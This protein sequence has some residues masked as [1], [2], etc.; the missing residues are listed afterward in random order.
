MPRKYPV[1]IEVTY[2]PLAGGA[3]TV[4]TE[5]AGRPL[6]R[7]RR[8][9][10]FQTQSIGDQGALLELHNVGWPY[11]SWESGGIIRIRA[12]PL[13]RADW[14]LAT[15]GY[16][17][18][19]KQP[20]GHRPVLQVPVLGP[21]AV[22]DSIV[23]T[24]D[25]T[26]TDAAWTTMYD[27]L[28]TTYLTGYTRTITADAAT[29]TA[30]FLAG[31]RLREALDRIRRSLIAATG[32][33]WEHLASKNGATREIRLFKRATTVQA[34]IR[35]AD[36][37][38]GTERSKGSWVDVVNKCTVFG[39]TVP[40]KVR[41]ETGLAKAGTVRLDNVLDL[42]AQ[43][44]VALDTPLYSHT[45]FADRSTGEDPPSL[46][47]KVARNSDN[48][49]VITEAIAKRYNAQELRR[50]AGTSAI[51]TD[52][53]YREF[54]A[55]DLGA[56]NA[57]AAAGIIV[58]SWSA[59]NVNPDW[60]VQGS[61]DDSSWT[62]VCA[63]V[64]GIGGNQTAT[65]TSP[66]AYR[67]WRL[68]YKHSTLISASLRE[69]R[70]NGYANLATDPATPS[71]IQRRTAITLATTGAQ[72]K[73][74]ARFD[75]GTARAVAKCAVQHS[76]GTTN[77]LRYLLVQVSADGSTWR[78]IGVL[79]S[80]TST[81]IDTFYVESGDW[82]YLRCIVQ[83]DRA[84]G[85]ASVNSTVHYLEV[86]WH[87]SYWVINGRDTEALAG[88]A[89]RG[90]AWTWGVGNLVQH[91]ALLE[92]Q[93]WPAP[94]LGLVA[95]R[96]YHHIY[97]PQA[98][99]SST[100]WWELDYG[101]NAA[102]PA[103][104]KKSTDGGATWTTV[105]ANAQFLHRTEF[106]NSQLSG[107]SEDAASQAKYANLVPGG[108]LYRSLVDPSLMTQD[109]VDRA[110]A[111]LVKAR[112][113]VKDRLTLVIPLNPGITVGSRVTVDQDCLVPLGTSGDFDVLEHRLELTRSGTSTLILNDHPARATDADVLIASV[114]TRGSL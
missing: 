97:T 70:L 26:F 106:N 98:G 73:E 34:T 67:Y 90:S 88:D 28:C 21:N 44:F 79:K 23:L 32:Q 89:M 60:K 40:K 82:R 104:A 46:A 77:T 99:A 31:T 55:W 48:L 6:H 83:D 9:T 52:D 62:D 7:I 42:A 4:I 91:P 92:K 16:V 20:A 61:N 17:G 75:F 65:V 39:A 37:L 72:T 58:A 1:S 78:D 8:C 76:H 14:I 80:T 64:A 96:F 13:N 63:E 107:T 2:T 51:P 93:T 95:G 54:I 86:Y 56:G 35:A 53:V 113:D 24:E 29:G 12:K 15:E 84:G 94:R 100:S 103:P 3:S 112:G 68:L 109:L 10:V 11:N 85:S 47:G 27:T 45:L 36:L 19:L 74:F 57:Q 59:S 71:D 50:F 43:P 38:K 81:V 110:A 111:A 108:I 22:L 105:E 41:D 102:G 30:T 33:F 69:L 114:A 5:E 66:T 101:V 87:L 18:E 49:S 25:V